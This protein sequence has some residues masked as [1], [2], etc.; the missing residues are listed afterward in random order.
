[1]A[2]EVRAGDMGVVYAEVRAG[3]GAY[4]GARTMGVVYG[5]IYAA[6][7]G[8]GTYADVRGVAYAGM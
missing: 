3:A 6:V 8:R 1:M 7:R 2:A 4:A 5:G